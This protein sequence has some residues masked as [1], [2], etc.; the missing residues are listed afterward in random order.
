MVKTE[1][2][3]PRMAFPYKNLFFN[4]CVYKLT[5][6]ISPMYCFSEFVTKQ[7]NQIP[8]STTANPTVEIYGRQRVFPNYFHAPVGKLKSN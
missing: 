4:F 8:L 5:R 3:L 7:P 6:L 1:K 2:Q